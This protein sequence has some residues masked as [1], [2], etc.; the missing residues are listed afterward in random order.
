MLKNNLK[1]VVKKKL[2][3]FQVGQEMLEKDRAIIKSVKIL[4]NN[5]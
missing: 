1:K 4:Q 5:F 3:I 2:M